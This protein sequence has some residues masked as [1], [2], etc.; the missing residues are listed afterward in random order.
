VGAARTKKVVL[1][2]GAFVAAGLLVW[3][4]APHGQDGHSDGHEARSK[5]PEFSG[6]PSREAPTPAE[7]IATRSVEDSLREIMAKWRTS[8]LK[9]DPEG[10]LDCD[11]IFQG[12]AQ[13]FIEPLRVSAKTD[14]DERVRAFSTRMLGK[15][16]DVSNRAFFA[17]LL[18]D[19]SPSVR[20]NAAWGLEQ[21]GVH[22]PPST[23]AQAGPA[24]K[25]GK[26]GKK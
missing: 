5:L 9:R 19:P 13:A 26:P 12:Q 4:L 2:V 25:P 16:H 14:E 21:L 7:P 20:G 6:I 15:L 1:G 17:A 22:T 3:V 24:R 8:I 11:N 18:D 10:V 23:V